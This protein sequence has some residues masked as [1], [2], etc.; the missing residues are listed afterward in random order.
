MSDE[1]TETKVTFY[2]VAILRFVER[3]GPYFDGWCDWEMSQVISVSMRYAVKR[4][5]IRTVWSGIHA[6]LLK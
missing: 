5:A 2:I 1:D 6:A 4:S 3:R